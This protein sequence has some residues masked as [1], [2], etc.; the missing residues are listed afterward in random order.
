MNQ[1]IKIINA[2]TIA[3]NIAFDSESG[4]QLEKNLPS[5]VVAADGSVTGLPTPQ[6]GKVFLVNARVFDATDREDFIKFHDLQAERDPKTGYVIRQQAFIA[7]DGVSQS[8]KR[9]M[10]N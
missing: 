2:L 4:I 7:R 3:P 10:F 8:F 9:E 6:S 5:P 1:K